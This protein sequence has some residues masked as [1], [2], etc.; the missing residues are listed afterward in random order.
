MNYKTNT[1]NFWF[2]T[3]TN[4]ETIIK[5]ASHSMEKGSRIA[6]KNWKFL[7]VGSSWKRRMASHPRVIFRV[8]HLNRKNG[9]LIPLYIPC[10]LNDNCEVCR[11]NCQKL[12]KGFNDFELVYRLKVVLQCG[13]L[14]GRVARTCLFS[15]WGKVTEDTAHL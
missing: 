5:T 8:P 6:A 11:K 1:N 2:M 13:T 12:E 7:A 10:V 9:T 15:I 3:T 4:L 14:R